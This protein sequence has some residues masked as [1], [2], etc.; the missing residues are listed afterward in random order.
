MYKLKLTLLQQELLG[1]LF[2]Y[3]EKSFTGRAVS[4]SLGASQPGVTKALTV[5][6]KEHII[7]FEKDKQSKRLAIRL[8]RNN[9]LVMG[10]KRADN[11]R[12]LYESGFTHFIEEQFPGATIILFGSYSRGDDTSASDIDIA[13]IGKKEK[14]I[15]LSA[16]EKLLSRKIVIQFYQSLAS[17]HK[18]LREN[19]CNGIILTG[20]I[21]L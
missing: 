10:L 15:D 19:L 8:N 9:D 5:L 11:L 12:N 4:L 16:Y 21:V 13:V 6:K 14:D 17:I 18:E 1:L 3:P 7:I 20:G 2:T